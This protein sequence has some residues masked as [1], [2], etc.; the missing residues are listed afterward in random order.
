MTLPSLLVAL[1]LGTARAAALGSFDAVS[2]LAAAHGRLRPRPL[3]QH[4]HPRPHL[5]DA[6]REEPPAA[7]PHQPGCPAGDGPRG[8]FVNVTEFGAACLPWAEVPAFV[9]KTPSGSGLRGRHNFC[10]NPDGRSR[11]WCFYRNPRGRLDWGYCDCK[12]GSVRLRGGKNEFE[13]TVEVYLNGIWGTICS[14]HWDNNDASVI[15]RQLELGK[16]GTANHTPFSGL[17]LVPVYWSDVRCHGD[18][19]NILLCE[20]DIWQGGSCPQ[21]MAAAVTCRFSHAAIFTPIRLTGGSSANEGRVE[22]YHAGQWGTVCDDQWDDADAEV[23]CRQLGLGGVAKAWSQA[24]FGEGSG[25][26]LL[27]E[28][29]CTGNELSIEQC[30]KS[31]WR[32]HNCGHKEDAGVSCTPLTDGAIRLADGKGSHEGRL[33]VHYSGQ[34]GTVC[35][36]GWTE[37]NTQVVCRQLGFKYGKSAPESYLEEST[38]PILLDDVSC[39]GKES[40]IL[41]CSKREWGKHDCSHQEDVRITCHPDNDSHRFSLGP[42]IRLMDGENKK[43]GRVEIFINGQWGTICDDGWSDKDAAVVCRQLGY[44]GPAR[45]RTMAYFGEG[46]GPIHVDNVKCTGNERSLTDCIKQDIGTHNCRHSEDAGVIC[47][48]LGKK[49]S[50]N[51]NKDSLTSVCGLRLLHRRQK[52]IIGGKNSLR[53]GWPWQV[54]LRLKSSHGDGRLLCGATLISSCW[55]LTAAHCFKRYGNNTRNYAVRVGDYHTLVPEEYEDEIGVQQIVM[56]KEY[57]PDSNDYDIALVR[58][59][60]PEEQCARFS[61]HVLPA[62]LPLRRERP[63]KTAPNCYITGWGDT[64]RAYSRTLQQAA[65]PLLPKRLCEERYKK[66]FTGRML[67]A[68]NLREQKHVD[69]CQGD[70]GGP[71]MCERPGESWVV[72]GVTSWGYGCGIK[73]SPGVYTKVSSFVPWIKNVTKL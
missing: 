23:V 13:G 56:H 64:G 22:V 48:Y 66:R 6:P 27:D 36:D 53:G 11:P 24:Y 21:K 58:L 7:P 49:A 1:L 14:S 65:I 2:P 60:G 44:K 52:R 57:R 67:C 40:T 30:P 59:H 33:E 70:S 42:P 69:S 71:L 35:D 32:E 63:Q 47:D 45:A 29:R 4:P 55:V 39:S 26:V 34:W 61:T 38:R 17:G 51:S 46:K 12:Q 25:P 8:R 28:V 9:A 5:P 43:E 19:E 62:C 31:S 15:C 73:D 50:G 20:K 37:L 41:Q 3:A 72:Y 54:A 10:R 16:S 18:E 68:G